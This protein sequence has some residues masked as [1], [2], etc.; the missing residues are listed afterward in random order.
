[1]E[2]LYTSKTFLKMADGKMHIPHRTPLGPPQGISY[3]NRQESLAYFSRLAPLLL[4]LFTKRQSRKGGS[5]AQY[6]QL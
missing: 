5:M 1:M 3:R 4:F 2:K 6:I